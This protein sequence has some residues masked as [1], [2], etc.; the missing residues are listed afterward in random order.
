ML[1]MVTWRRPSATTTSCSASR[2]ARASRTSRARSGSSRA[3]C[4]PTSPRRP[5]RRSGSARSPRR[6]RCSRTPRRASSTTATATPACAAAASRPGR[7]TSGASPT[8]SPRSS[9]TTSSAIGGRTRRARGA[10]I[11]AEV[12]IELV[13]AARGVTRDV[14]FRVSRHLRQVQRQRR[15][16]GDERRSRA[17]RAAAR[18]RVQ[19]VSR[20]VFGEFV[21]TS[22]VPAVRRRGPDRHDAVHASAKASGRT[23]AERRLDVDDP[24]RHPRRPADPDQRRGPRRSSSAG[25]RATSTSACACEPDPRFVRDGDDIFSTVDLNIV[26]AALGTQTTR[27]DARG[28]DRARVPGRHAARRGA[29]APR[30]RHAGAAGLRPRRPARARQRRRA[31]PPHARSS[32]GCSRSSSASRPTRRTSRTKASSTS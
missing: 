26:E 8:S 3:S 18:G 15:R 4:T 9:A 19:Q 23:I 1:N 31:A 28:P 21:R 27:R 13:E 7:S 24:R 30:S 20:S 6:T 29:R 11:A 22:D 5:T 2:A 16:A 17:R 32:G 14:P 10:D 12:E 25:A